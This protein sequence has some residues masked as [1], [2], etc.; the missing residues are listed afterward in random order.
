MKN[1]GKFEVL[2]NIDKY[3]IVYIEKGEQLYL[4]E[5]NDKY[6][7]GSYDEAL[8]YV[9]N[10]KGELDKFVTDY[11]EKIRQ[12]A[13]RRIAEENARK[14]AERKQ[15][16]EKEKRQAERKEKRRGF[17]YSV[18]GIIASI[19]ATAILLTGGHFAGV[20][21]SKLVEKNKKASTSQS[22]QDDKGES[23][24]TPKYS[25]DY[26]KNVVVVDNEEYVELTTEEFENITALKIKELSDKGITL[27]SED[28]IKY[29]MI[30][31]CDK[32]AQDNKELISEIMGE[33]T[34]D[35][36]QQDANKYVGAVVMY[37][38]NIWYEEGSTKNFIK[39]SDTIFDEEARNKVIE[40]E[41][42]V[43]EITL[44][45]E[46]NDKFNE[47]VN[48]LLKEL[49]DPTN[50]LS[51]LE[52]GVGYALQIVLEPIRGL[53]GDG[54][55]NEANANLIKYFVPYAGDEEEYKENNM[56]TGYIKDINDILSDCLENSKKL[57]K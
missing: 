12:E 9:K 15:K 10:N 2:K 25:Y 38:Y 21:I 1:K 36:L 57:T 16:E 13:E 17:W 42:R 41:K 39:A 49:L 55:L 45:M 44:S 26:N 6:S 51:Y 27:N 35:E 29:M 43:D 23:D 3:V 8:D 48:D 30:A 28:I 32:L 14:E 4:N 7:F 37:N 34:S 54:R 19:V 40:I 52:S 20:G 56:L 22:S 24:K 53:Y 33:Q 31:N 50:E 5:L 11:K 18:K 46:D 47:L